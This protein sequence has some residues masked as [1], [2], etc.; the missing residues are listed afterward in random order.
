MVSLK[1]F[2]SKQQMFVPVHAFSQ[3]ILA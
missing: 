3:N 2:I 1:L